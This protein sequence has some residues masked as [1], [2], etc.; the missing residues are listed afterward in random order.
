M[1]DS[2]PDGKI[3][4]GAPTAERIPES[5]RVDVVVNARHIRLKRFPWLFPLFVFVET[6]SLNEGEPSVP[7]H[8][9]SG[10]VSPGH[11]MVPAVSA[12]GSDT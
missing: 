4:F 9:Q 2:K 11:G 6:E 3:N 10:D 1:T 7:E 8:A 12:A 5:D